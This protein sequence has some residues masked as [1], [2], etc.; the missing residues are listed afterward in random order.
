MQVSEEDIVFSKLSFEEF[1]ELCFD[2]ILRLGFHS[3]IWRKGAADDGRDIEASFTVTNPIVKSYTERWFF[4]CKLYSTGIPPDELTS[5]IAWAD[6]E[7][8]R[9]FALLTTSH[10]TNGCR[11]WLEKIRPEKSYVIHL[12]E[13]KQL[14]GLLLAV[15]EL[16]VKYFYDECSKLIANARQSWLLHG[17]F[18]DPQTFFVIHKKVDPRKLSREDLAFLWCAYHYKSSEIDDWCEFDQDNLW[19][20]DDAFTF[21][22]LGDYIRAMNDGQKPLDMDFPYH[23]RPSLG[24]RLIVSSPSKV[25]GNMEWIYCYVQDKEDRAIEVKIES[26]GN[27]ETLIRDIPVRKA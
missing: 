1:E 16:V 24:M 4:E 10:L 22:F 7:K 23:P 25:N 26:K 17:L 2:L 27:G 6:A 9:H 14:K 15:P 3:P 18:P 19:N 11:N 21:D 20:Q 12:I 13:G 8:P 5:K